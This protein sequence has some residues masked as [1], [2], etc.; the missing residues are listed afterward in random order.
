LYQKSKYEIKRE[1]KNPI[2]GYHGDRQKRKTEYGLRLR[3]IFGRDPRGTVKHVWCLPQMAFT[4][5]VFALSRDALSRKYHDCGRLRSGTTKNFFI[6][7]STTIYDGSNG[8]GN[9]CVECL[10]LGTIMGQHLA[11]LVSALRVAIVILLHSG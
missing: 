4:V 2:L 3:D 6:R 10:I 7:Q 5:R 1:K 8:V 9:G 11:E